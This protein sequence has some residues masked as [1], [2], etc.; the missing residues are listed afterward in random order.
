MCEEFLR[1]K[2][3]GIKFEYPKEYVEFI[4]NRGKLNEQKT[5]I[6]T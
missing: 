1:A 3:L 6:Y 2:S 4:Q 5:T